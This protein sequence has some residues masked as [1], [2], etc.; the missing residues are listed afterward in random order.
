MAK[1]HLDSLAV[2]IPLAQP[3]RIAVV[4]DIVTK[5]ATLLAV[6]SLVK[7][8]FPQADVSVFAVLRTMGLQPEV[9]RILEPCVGVIRLTAWGEVDRQP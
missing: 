2:D 9:E 8:A 6:A 5:G 3:P 4:D 1:A 7:D